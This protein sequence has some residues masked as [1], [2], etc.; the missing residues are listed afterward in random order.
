MFLSSAKIR[1]ALLTQVDVKMIVV[2]SMDQNPTVKFQLL[3]MGGWRS[4]KQKQKDQRE[5]DAQQGQ[6]PTTL[7]KTVFSFLNKHARDGDGQHGDPKHIRII[8]PPFVGVNV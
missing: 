2:L 1:I 3:K 4:R 5:E 7:T 6:L 8:N